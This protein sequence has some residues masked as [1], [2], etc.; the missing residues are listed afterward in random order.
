MCDEFEVVGFNKSNSYK[1]QQVK[2]KNENVLRLSVE[3]VDV[4]V[5]KD[6]I[7]RERGIRWGLPHDIH[8]FFAFS[9]SLHLPAKVAIWKVVDAKTT[10][11]TTSLW[12]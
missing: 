3:C 2:L 10:V 1:F 7:V 6:V 5:S 12:N 11:S 8:A 9:L 4:T